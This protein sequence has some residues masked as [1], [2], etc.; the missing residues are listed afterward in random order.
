MNDLFLYPTNTP[1]GSVLNETTR[2]TLS[3]FL[4]WST[5][6]SMRWSLSYLILLPS[7]FTTS[8]YERSEHLK[9]SRLVFI[10]SWSYHVSW[11][12]LN[13]PLVQ[14]NSNR[15]SHHLVIYSSSILINKICIYHKTCDQMISKIRSNW[16]LGNAL[17][18]YVSK[19]MIP[20]IHF[21]QTF[22]MHLNKYLLWSIWTIH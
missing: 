17:L 7:R 6:F 3:H 13:G 12:N 10:R 14:T 4:R 22:W 8:F 5:K 21:T 19:T 1:S 2:E 16:I 9:G 15:Y 20:Q 11:F 18:I